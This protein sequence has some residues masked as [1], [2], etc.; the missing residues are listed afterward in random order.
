MGRR[1]DLRALFVV[2]HVNPMRG[3]EI[4]QVTDAE[5]VRE[6]LQGSDRAFGELVRRYQD[7]LYRHAERMTGRQDDAE[8]VV[9]LAFIKAH[10][11]LDK[12]RDPE[13]VGAWLFRIGANV[14]KDFLKSRRAT[15]SLEQVPGL[16]A[17][18]DDPQREAEMGS[19]RDQIEL[20]LQSLGVEQR[21]AFVMKHVEGWSYVEMAEAL[22]VSVPA[23]K[24]RV[25][26]AR[27]ELQV[28]LESCGR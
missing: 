3:L 28:L 8:D 26:R 5:L 24:M 22:S 4:R 17:T 25:H 20:A 12:C 21:E 23:L 15:V 2:L 10:R 11:S 14:C 9:Q 7:L 19:M 6:A 16:P 13:R 1:C 27:E 18:A